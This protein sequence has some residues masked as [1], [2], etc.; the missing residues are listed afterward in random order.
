MATGSSKPDY[1]PL[2]SAGFHPLGIKKFHALVVGAFPLSTTR[3]D[4]MNGLMVVRK[5]LLKAKIRGQLWVDGSFVTR[6]IDP[7]D[8][9]VVLHIDTKEYDV[10]TQE[11]RD[12]IDWVKSNLEVTHKVHSFVLTRYPKG[13]GEHGM[14]TWMKAYWTRQ[15]G[16]GRHGANVKGMVVLK[17]S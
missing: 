16:F 11:K 5:V 13:H 17:L 9:D 1:P 3:V 6:K 12:A 2:L 15:F 4:I 8:A 10:G 14:Y 7:N